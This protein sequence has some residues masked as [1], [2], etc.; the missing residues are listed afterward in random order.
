[1]PQQDTG[2]TEGRKQTRPWSGNEPKSHREKKNLPTPIVL[3]IFI[4]TFYISKQSLNSDKL[5]H[6]S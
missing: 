1:M 6:F 5:S 4:H 2:V 3:L